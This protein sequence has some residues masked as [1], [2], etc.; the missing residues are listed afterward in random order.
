MTLSIDICHAL[1]NAKF[2]ATVR[3]VQGT[4][5]MGIYIFR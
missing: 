4:G 1:T 2:T 3:D 5:E